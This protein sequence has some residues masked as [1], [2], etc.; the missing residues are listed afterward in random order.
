MNMRKNRYQQVVRLISV[1][2]GFDEDVV[3]VFCS[4]RYNYIGQLIEEK[5]TLHEIADDLVHR[6][7]STEWFARTIN[8]LEEPNNGPTT[9]ST[10]PEDYIE[11]LL[12]DPDLKL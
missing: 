3:A 1:E 5:K 2:H 8:N 9:S 12:Q 10:S 7:H 6:M 4:M 11:F